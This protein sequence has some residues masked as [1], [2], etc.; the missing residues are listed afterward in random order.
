M[1][2]SKIPDPTEPEPADL[3]ALSRQELEELAWHFH[4]LARSFVDR[5][6]EDFT[7]SPLP[8]SSE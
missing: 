6:G 3:S 5:L 4:E 1:P 8:P 2:S 7:T